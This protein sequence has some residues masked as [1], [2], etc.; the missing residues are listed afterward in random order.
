MKKLTPQ[1]L[2]KLQNL[3][4]QKNT[5]SMNIGIAAVTKEIEVRKANQILNN[6]NANFQKTLEL[7]MNHSKII[8]SKTEDFV[9]ELNKKYGNH[10]YNL[11]T[12]ELIEPPKE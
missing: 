1:E 3:V 10:Q 12:G 8:E 4:T 5:C 7:E 2:E 11:E 6:A 9:N